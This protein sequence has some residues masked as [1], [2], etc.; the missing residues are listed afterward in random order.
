MHSNILWEERKIKFH[1]LNILFIWIDVSTCSKGF[2]FEIRQPSQKAAK[3][4]TK[5]WKT[6]I[7][8]QNWWKKEGRIDKRR[9]VSREYRRQDRAQEERTGPLLIWTSTKINKQDKIPYIQISCYSKKNVNSIETWS[10]KLEESKFL[11]CS[12]IAYFKC[13]FNWSNF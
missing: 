3:G 8:K 7:K 12:S 9:H 6:W 13:V 5:K 2:C 4:D 1:N 11:L 10:M